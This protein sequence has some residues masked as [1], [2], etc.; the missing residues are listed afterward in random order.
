MAPRCVS[1]ETVDTFTET[2]HYE[3]KLQKL[4]W[5]DAEVN[6]PTSKMPKMQ[7]TSY[8]WRMPKSHELLFAMRDSSIQAFDANARFEETNRLKVDYNLRANYISLAANRWLTVR[9]EFFSNIL[10]F[11]TA[12]LAV[13]EA[14]P[15]A[16]VD[17]C[18]SLLLLDLH[19][20]PL[21]A[22]ALVP[23]AT[24]AAVGT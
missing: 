22:L 16:A 6:S 10:L 9:L 12:L 23:T 18:V 5:E 21:G 8:E 17:R 1:I 20:P 24:R 13:V 19:R 3:V 4:V 2:L 7:R 11:L 14:A 15:K